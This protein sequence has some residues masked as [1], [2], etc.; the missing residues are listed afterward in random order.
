L[1]KDHSGIRTGS[2][3]DGYDITS[4]NPLCSVSVINSRA[5]RTRMYIGIDIKD[6]SSFVAAIGNIVPSSC[7]TISKTASESR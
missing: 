4:E 6:L 3:L 5:R 7:S 1:G 2:H